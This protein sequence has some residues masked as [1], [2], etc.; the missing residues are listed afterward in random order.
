MGC[1]K[2][3]TAPPDVRRPAPDPRA[4]QHAAVAR[5]WRC[6]VGSLL[7]ALL[8]SVLA[9]SAEARG[10]RDRLVIGVTQFPFTLHPTIESMLAKTYV[11]GMAR[12]PL[13]AYDAEWRL[14]CLL[15][16]ELPTLENGGAVRETTP[17]GQAGVAVTFT[18]RPEAR[19]GDGTPVTTRDV[20]FTWEVGRHPMSAVIPKEFYRRVYRVSVADD[21]TFT[22]HVDRLHFDYNAV[23]SF[24]L[25]PAHLEAPVFE[26]AETYR[27]R[28]LYETDP[29]NPGLYMG[30]YVIDEVV[31]GSHIG[32]VRNP[33]WWGAPPSFERI[34]V[35]VIEN[36]AALE[37]NL[38]SGAVDMIAGEL[39]VTLD[40]A[41]AFE[42]R[43]GDRFTVVYEPG[44][45][46]EHVDLN[47]DNPILADLRVRRALLYAIDR[48][49][50]SR[51]LFD[52]RQPVAH[53]N[54]NP[55]DRMHADDVPVYAHDP[56]RAAALLAEAGWGTVRRGVRVD[57]AGQPLALEIMTTAGN[58][59]RELVQQVLQ[60]QWRAQ[61]IDVRIRNQPARVFFGETVT[62]RQFPAMAM[63][64]WISAPESVPRTTLHSESIPTAD[65][66]WSGQNTTGFRNAEVDALIDAIEVELDAVKRRE[67]W[68]RL[69]H[70]Y[71]E[72]LP[73]LPLYFRANPHIHPTWLKGLVPTGHMDPSTLWVEHWHAE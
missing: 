33:E 19:W 17:D 49:A 57:A 26:P 54:V 43:H 10:G 22:L 37:A 8:V 9:V 45:V 2:P 27:N 47:L 23:N 24:D 29:T 44:L 6:A 51:Q 20:L 35:R 40:Q 34:V 71:A 3:T 59:S 53:S 52:G 16:V 64:A 55:L 41:L 60:S 36:T 18:I 38:L 68:R 4:P 48:E 42:K 39:G 65:N 32:L 28:T 66:N 56:E 1:S 12:R 69:Q 11:L 30:P 63:Y 72:E 15:C 61:G 50:I 67:M 13:T 58:R 25:L 31:A 62:R 21:H 73:V 7:A 14:V 5:A 70:I 46:Y